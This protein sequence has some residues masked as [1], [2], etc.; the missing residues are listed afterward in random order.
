M[1]L[2][3]LV[4]LFLL[5]IQRKRSKQ[6]SKT[7][8]YTLTLT[9]KSR[10]LFKTGVIENAERLWLVTRYALRPIYIKTHL[11]TQVAS[12]NADATANQKCQ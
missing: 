9:R 12:R 5:Y 7:K 11:S 1:K 8:I 10:K 4:T 6:N 3:K 2:K